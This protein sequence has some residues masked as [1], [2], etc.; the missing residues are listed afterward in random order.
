MVCYGHYAGRCLFCFMYR[1]LK[2]LTWFLAVLPLSVARGVGRGLGTLGYLLIRR[3]RVT[4]L[5]EMARCFPDES[6]ATLKRRLRRVYQGMAVNYI[7]VFR[8]IGGADADLDAQVRPQGMEHLEEALAHGK[9]VLILTA[10]IGNWDM[11]GLWGARR[12]KLTIISK[13]LRGAG[14]NRFW[15]EARARCGLQIVPAHNSYR[16]CISVLR[17]NEILGFILDQN[18]TRMEGIF[19]DFFGKPACTTAGLAFMAAHSQAP[20]VPAFM[21]REPDGSHRIEI[22]PAIEPPP[23]RDAETLRA[24]TQHYTSVIEG[25]IRQVPDQ[26]IWMHRRWRTQPLPVEQNTNVEVK[27]QKL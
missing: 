16:A 22:H 12:M 2:I 17:K 9:G 11:L 4:N 6:R 21:I 5:A 24:A 15:M 25:V 3:H 10:H 26:W 27:K 19:V 8:W 1:V 23:N 18:M 13:D 7:E 14:V 20:I